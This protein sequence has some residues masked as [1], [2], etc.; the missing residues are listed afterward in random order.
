MENNFS[1]DSVSK[2]AEI[3]VIVNR[4]IEKSIFEEL[5]RLNIISE[6][7]DIY[8]PEVINKLTLN[9]SPEKYVGNGYSKSTIVSYDGKEILLFVEKVSMES[10]DIN[11]N[12][13]TLRPN[14]KNE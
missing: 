5:K 1:F 10:T 7:N 4:G 9:I 11:V 6:E 2:T 3:A 12:L 13:I 14:K 8:K